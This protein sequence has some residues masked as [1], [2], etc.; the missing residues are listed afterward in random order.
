MN[1]REFQKALITGRTGATGSGGAVPTTLGQHRNRCPECA[2]FAARFESA[3]ELLELPASHDPRPRPGF[4]SRVVASLPERESPLAWATVRLLP[5][6]T[7]LALT[8]LGWCWI[9]TP[10]PTE[11]LAQ[12]GVDEVLAWVLSESGDDP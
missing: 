11:L 7:A 5:A 12:A 9:T 2:R 4:S 6:T 3:R 8:L 10:S 1:C